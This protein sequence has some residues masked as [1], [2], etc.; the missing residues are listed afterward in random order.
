MLNLSPKSAPKRAFEN[1]TGLRRKSPLERALE[2]VGDSLGAIGDARPS[3]SDV[4]SGTA[5]KTSLM[6]AGG[7]A[8]LTAGS[9]AISSLR[10]RLDGAGD[11]S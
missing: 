7:V 10:R 3:L 1:V 8:G 11:D 2:T 4:T 5:R 6:V 9:A